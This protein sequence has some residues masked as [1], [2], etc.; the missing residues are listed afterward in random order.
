MRNKEC[1]TCGHRADQHIY[2][3][4]A[5]RPGWACESSCEAFT[6]P[7]SDTVTITISREDAEGWRAADFTELRRVAEA[8]TQAEWLHNS[9]KWDGQYIGS[10]TRMGEPEGEEWAICDLS[11]FGRPENGRHIAT[12]DPPTVLALLDEIERLRAAL[13]EERWLPA[14]A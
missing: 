1:F 11:E 13:E 3:E 9:G 6:Q 5:C 8:A 10:V 7:K 2:G 4:G 14:R 12:F